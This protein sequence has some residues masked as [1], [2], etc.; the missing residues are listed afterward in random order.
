M[1]FLV[2]VTKKGFRCL[3]LTG[4]HSCCQGH[5]GSVHRE[6]F[7]ENT[8]CNCATVFF[9]IG[10][11]VDMFIIAATVSPLGMTSRVLFLVLTSL[12]TSNYLQSINVYI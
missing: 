6:C 1:I 9:S 3:V 7:S 12:L 5:V 10:G 8:L 2:P 4:A 11:N